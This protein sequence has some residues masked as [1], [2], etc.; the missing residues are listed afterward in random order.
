MASN[1]PDRSTWRLAGR[2]MN[3]R[4]VET[5]RSTPSILALLGLDPEALQAVRK[6]RTSTLAAPERRSAGRR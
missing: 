2:E 5:P 3:D 6:D 4:Q 1:I